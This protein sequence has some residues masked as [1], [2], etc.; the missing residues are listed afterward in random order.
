MPRGD[1]VDE[2]VDRD[3]RVIELEAGLRRAD[4]I[5]TLRDEV[6][7]VREQLASEREQLVNEKGRYKELWSKYCERLL[8]DDELIALKGREVEELRK[9]LSDHEHPSRSPSRADT[10]L[11]ADPDSRVPSSTS[12]TLLSRPLGTSPKA[13]TASVAARST[14]VDALSSRPLGTSPKAST[15]SVVASSTP[16]DA[17]SSK[18]PGTLLKSSTTS[19]VAGTPTAA[20]TS[21]RRG[22]APPVDTFNGDANF[23][24]WLPALQRSATWNAWTDDETLLQLAG[25]LRGRAL[26]EWN[27]M[28][29]SDRS[30]LK[31]ATNVLKE[32]L[33]P[34]SRM[35]AA[36]DPSCYTRSR[37][38]YCRLHP[39]FREAVPHSIRAGGHVIGCA[40]C[41]ALQPD[42]GGP[43]A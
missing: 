3:A 36:Q 6:S 14:P 17:L 25:H 42:A 18:S 38:A 24:D 30:D 19:V 34:S 23:E 28:D 7:S 8:R 33:D 13:S 9:R 22:K 37:R 31:R 15:A 26:E 4:E 27:L 12:D 10:P 11:H 40:R 39:T 16:V 21:S 5:E 35:L 1:G 29:G 20:G 41:P 2:A 43:E 32:R